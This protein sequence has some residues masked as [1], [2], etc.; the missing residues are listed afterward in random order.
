MSKTKNTGVRTSC[1]GCLKEL[2]A[3]AKVKILTTLISNKNKP[4]T[5]GE[6]VTILKLRQP[7]VS[8]HLKALKDAGLLVSEKQGR[9]VF[10]SLSAECGKNHQ[11]CFLTK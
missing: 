10:Y 8:F 9:Q 6:F 4:K 11:P 7:T 3:E 5:V 2:G 1:V